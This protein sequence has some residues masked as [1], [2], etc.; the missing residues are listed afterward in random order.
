MPAENPPPPP[1]TPRVALPTLVVAELQ[2]SLLVAMH[3][4]HRLEGLLTHAA[5]CLLQRFSSASESLGDARMADSEPLLQARAA[6]R[7][8]ICELQFQDLASQLIVHTTRVLEG[9]AWRLAS[10]GMGLDDGDEAAA[11]PEPLQARFAERPNPV[12]QSVVDAGS[13]ELF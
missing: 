13:V 10:E 7:E 1:E 11:A 8:A 2:D 5:E 12:T 6:L 9:C 4:L 3:D